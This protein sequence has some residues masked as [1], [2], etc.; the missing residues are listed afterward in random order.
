MRVASVVSC[1][2][3]LGCTGQLSEVQTHRGGPRLVDGGP[4]ADGS[5]VPPAPGEDAGPDGR[6]APPT[7]GDECGDSR[8]VARVY[9]GTLEPTYLPLT[10]GQ[11]MAVGTFGGCSGL[12]ITP[13]WVLTAAHCGLRTG[14]R[15]CIGAEPS[16][17]EHCFEAARVVDNPR[18]DMTLVEL[19]G[20]AVERVPE[21]VPVP[22]LTE[23]LD[24]SW[25]GRT[26]EAAGYGQTETGSSGT[27]KFTAEPIVSLSGDTLT[28]DG[29]GRRGVCFGDS[30][31]PVMV[32][33]GDGTVRVAG[34]LSNG[35]GSCVGRDN[36]TRVDVYRD[37][38]E[39]YT[40]PT[41]VGGA[42]CGE[43]DPVGRCMDGAATWCRGDELETERCAGDCGWD[44]AAG[45]FRCIEGSDPCGGVDAF[46][47]CDGQVARWCEGGVPRSRDCGACGE[48][49]QIVPEVG[50]VYCR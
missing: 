44:G 3:V 16:R 2:L 41:V 46:G 12:L 21:V 9:Y 4:P 48:S 5:A 28:I 27:R 31:G 38:I 24:G 20:S 14:A 32:I 45:G 29:E 36:Y 50:G 39:G 26:A 47:A 10:P 1:A 7:P 43:I 15:F 35:D 49:C 17:P 19:S 18:G 34:D 42:P 23:E 6:P 33:A 40:G 37:W 22:I 30:G 13:T 11:A 8:T 25:T